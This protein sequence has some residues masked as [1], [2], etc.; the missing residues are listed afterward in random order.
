[1]IRVLGGWNVRT[2]KALSAA[3]V[4]V[5]VISGMTWI[6]VGL[7]VHD[8]IPTMRGVGP[9]IQDPAFP[10]VDPV[11]GTPAQWVSSVCAPHIHQT[12]SASGQR[13]LSGIGFLYPNTEFM[14]PRSTYSAICRARVASA[15]DRVLLLAEYSAE[16]P[17]PVSYTHLTLPTNR[18]V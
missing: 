3:V 11:S 2:V 10:T 16:D 1:M 12:R 14:L 18:E 6:G 15:S 13:P 9:P 7:Q 4:I 17:M 8:G 5:A